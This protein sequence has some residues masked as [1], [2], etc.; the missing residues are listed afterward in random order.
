MKKIRVKNDKLVATMARSAVDSVSLSEM[1]GISRT[2]I[3]RLIN[4]RQAP[5]RDTASQI[6]DALSVGVEE[7]G[8][9]YL[10]AEPSRLC[11]L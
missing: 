10:Y 3:S 5:R 4:N 1:T 7:L 9:E 6:A 8:F 2:T 11:H